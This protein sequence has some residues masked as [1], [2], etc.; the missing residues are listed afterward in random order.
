MAPFDFLSIA[1]TPMF[2]AWQRAAA[3]MMTAAARDP[4]LMK[5]SAGMMRSQ[6]LWGRAFNNAWQASWAPIDALADRDGSN[7]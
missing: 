2:S 4:R 3:E 6:L 7:V 5:L 1:A